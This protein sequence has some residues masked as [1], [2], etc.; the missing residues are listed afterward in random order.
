MWSRTTAFLQGVNDLVIKPIT[1]YMGMYL[2]IQKVNH[3]L[4]P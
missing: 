4:F 2:L 3:L 1:A